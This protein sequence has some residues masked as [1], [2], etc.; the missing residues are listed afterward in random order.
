MGATRRRSSLAA[1]GCVA[2]AAA[3][4]LGLAGCGSPGVGDVEEKLA[5]EFP[6]EAKK[7]KADI[8]LT[9]D[10]TCPKDASVKKGAEFACTVPATQAGK[11]VVITIGV[12]MTADD[13]FNY[14]IAKITPATGAAPAQ[15]TTN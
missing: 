7:Q 15:T 8:A 14:N 4:S 5:T 13:K 6:K 9:G 2:V 11:K 10:V 1:A 12:V 3:A